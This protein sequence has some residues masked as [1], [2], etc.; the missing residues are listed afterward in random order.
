[1]LISKL[2]SVGRDNA[3]FVPIERES[4]AIVGFSFEFPQEASSSDQFW[5]MICEGRSAST[6][7]PGDRLNIQTFY[8]PDESR[9]ST[10]PVLGGNFVR[11][12]LGKFDAPFFSISPG[13]A[14]FMDPQHRRML[15]TAYRALEDAGIPMEKCAGSDTSVYTGCFTNDYL[16]ILQQDYEAEQTH[17]AVGIAPSMLANRV[18]WF[19][20]FK[21]TSMNIDSACSSSL[22]ALHLACQELLSGS[23][24][25]VNLSS[26]VKWALNQS[27]KR[28]ALVGGANLIFHPNFMKMMSSF[29][30]LSPD[31][32]CWSFDER[33]NGYA[34]GEGCAMLVV[35]RLGD[36]LRDG[37]TIRAVI[38]NTGTNQDGRTPGITQPNPD[39]QVDLIERTYREANIDMDP[40]RFF[41]AHGTGTPVGDPIEANAIGQAFKHCRSTA[42]P[43]YIGTVKANIGHLEGASGLA[44]II[45][46][47]LVLEHGL[48]P[49]IAGLNTLNGRIDADKLFLKFP[50]EMIPWPTS[51][52][53]RACVNSFG[54]GGTNAIVILDDA[55]H[56]LSSR[57]LRGYSRTRPAPHSLHSTFSNADNP[58]R[59]L[60]ESENS[61]NRGDQ[62]LDFEKYSCDYK[63]P[64]LLVLSASDKV[65]CQTMALQFCG[66]IKQY[67]DELANLAYSLAV[68]RSLLTW[69][70]YIVTDV[71]NM[72]IIDELTLP[73]PVR[74]RE[75]VRLAFIFTGQG[76]QY[77]GMGRELLCFPVFQN[78]L[79]LLQ[80]CLERLGASWSLHEF[81]NNEQIDASIDEPRYS[82]PLTTCLQIALVD[83]I[84]SFGILP[85]IVLG[86]SS[87]EIAA[88]YATGGLS[89]FS[90]VKI[91]YYRGLLSSRLAARELGTSMMAVG[92]SRE[93]IVPYFSR[94]KQHAGD[95]EVSIGCVNSPRD[96]TLTGKTQQMEILRQWLEKDLIFARRI[97]VP[98][99]YH[100]VLMNE[101]SDE[102]RYAMQ[103]LKA[104]D[105]R[106][107]TL[108]M[109]S[110]TCGIVALQTLCTVEYWIQN[111]TSTV[112]FEGA[113]NKLLAQTDKK[114]SSQFGQSQTLDRHISHILEI[115]P[116]NAL[117]RPI[118]EILKASP[119]KE[120]PSYIPSLRRRFNAAQ[121]LALAM[122]E[123]HCAGY[124]VNLHAVNSIGEMPHPLP[125]NMPPY[126]FNHSKSYWK[127]GRLSKNFRFQDKARH[128]LLGMRHLDWNPQVAQWRNVVR[129]S[130]LPW[131]RDH[132]IDGQIVL[133]AACMAV[134]ALE[135]FRQLNHARA[136]LNAI[137]IKDV[138]FFHPLRF[139]NSTEEVETQLTLSSANH[140]S[141]DWSWSH[142]RLFV[143]ENETYVECSAGFI[144]GDFSEET[145][146]PHVSFLSGLTVQNWIAEISSAC[147]HTHDPYN[148]R[149]RSTVLYGPSFQMLENM[150]VGPNG[151]ATAT[152]NTESRRLT[153]TRKQQVQQYAIHPCTLDGLA[154]LMV[155]ALSHVREDLP[156]M[157]PLYA[158]NIWIDCRGNP[159]SRDGKL[160]GAARCTL[161]GRRGA[162]AN[163]I[164]TLPGSAEPVIYFENLE[165]AYIE[166]SSDLEPV[167]EIKRNLCTRMSWK[168]DIDMLDCDQLM[169]EIGRNRPKET[170]NAV[171]KNEDLTL[172]IL[173]FIE[174]AA[175]YLEEHS[176]AS[177]PEY[178]FHYTSWITY[179][180]N[181]L[182]N[183]KLRTEIRHLLSR[184]EER[185]MLVTQVEEAGVDGQFFM[186]VGR[187]LI[188]VLSG[189]TD[190]LDLMFQHGLADHYYENVLANPYHA[191]PTSVIVNQLCFKNPLM[192]VLEIGAGTGG[193]TLQVL[194]ALCSNGVSKC[195]RYDY[196]D[197]SPKFFSRAKEKFRNYTDILRFRVGDISKDPVSQGFEPA[198]YDLVIAS[199]VLHAT[200][201]L[202]E[203][204]ENIRKL[205][206]PGGRLLL[207]ETTRPEALHIGFAFGL[208]KGWWSPLAHEPRSAHS[209]CITS[210]QWNERL[211]SAGFSGVD[212]DISGQENER[213]RYSSIMITTANASDSGM[214]DPK[215]DVILIRD[216]HEPY[217][218]LVAESVAAGLTSKTLT[219]EEM[220]KIRVLPSTIVIFLLEMQQ[221]ILDGISATNFDHLRN[222][223]FQAQN[224]I[225]ITESSEQKQMPQH[226]MIEGVCR[227]LCSEDSSRKFVTLALDGSETMEQLL[228]FL[229]QIVRNV[230]SI[231]VDALETHYSSRNAILQI[232]R[233]IENWTMNDQVSRKIRLRERTEQELSR[234]VQA[235]IR[236]TTPGL[237]QT[238]EFVEDEP[239]LSALQDDELLVAVKAI[240]LTF[241]DYLVAAGEV[242]QAN[243]GTECAGVIQKAGASTGFRPGDRVFLIGTALARTLVRVKAS[244]AAAIPLGM[245]FAESASLPTSLWLAYYALHKLSMLH[246]GE[247]VLIHQA[248]SSVGQLLVQL[249][250]K[251]GA[252]ILATVGSDSKKRFLL[253]RFEVPA[254]NIF[255]SN[256]PSICRMI[257]LIT[258]GRGVDVVVGS[259]A[260]W[261]GQDLS[262]CLAAY[263]RV[264]DIG[265]NNSIAHNMA[266]PKTRVMNICRSTVSFVDLVREKP[267]L[268]YDTFQQAIKIWSEHKISAPQPLNSFPAGNISNA[269]RQFQ[270][271]R[272][273]GKPVLEMND[274]MS[275][276]VNSATKPKYQFSESASYVIAGGLGGLGRSFARWMVRRGARY[277]ILLSRSGPKSSVA[278]ELISELEAQHVIVATPQIDI[279]NLSG[280]KQVLS[281]LSLT[282]PPIRGCIQASSAIRDNL[283]QNMTHDDWEISTSSKVAGS[284]NLHQL[285]PEDL[286][287][288]ILISSINGIF[289]NRGQANYAAG[290]AFKD[291]LAHYRL[292]HGLKA[293]SI[294][295]GLMVDEGVVAESELLLRLMR[296]NG[297]LME[298]KQE[299]LIALLDY[300]CD[301]QLPLLTDEEA[302]I[303]VGIEMPSAIIAKGI[304]LHHSIR[305]PIF[306]H[307]FCM[308]LDVVPTAPESGTSGVIDHPAALKS[309]TSLEEA[310]SLVTEWI[311][312]KLG[313]LL[314]QPASDIVAEKPIHAY[315]MDSLIAVDFKN[316]FH[317]SIG[318][319]ITVF[320]LM[321][322]ASLRQLSAV[323]AERSRYR[324]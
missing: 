122:G 289:G 115:G 71:H 102:Y 280:L 67:P 117:Q 173:C 171:V 316:W 21:G 56:Y 283:F 211:Q 169:S 149:S 255:I 61:T 144:R 231:H 145:R 202:D 286:D 241:R 270:D 219:L 295:L 154:Q 85:A 224:T 105:G 197:I 77:M 26:T 309:A 237:L 232:P 284:W 107:H 304:D 298:V 282:M 220:S 210:A 74:S 44:G 138:A 60:I 193:Q 94:L 140:S 86:H 188:S 103:G 157:V 136:D 50:K 275:V 318:A 274:S 194:E 179:Q 133:P 131:L 89:R 106:S 259:L 294:D 143:M 159:L 192:N 51:G 66:Y 5:Q 7:F 200:N 261:K 315:G 265:V 134:M 278:R 181:R 235:S 13:E 221:F 57:G 226:G 312:I 165:T 40:T 213:Y 137:H 49:P 28:Q 64:K 252:N 257:H 195:A 319:N 124:P 147:E 167:E 114:P 20:N 204:L 22:V 196:T 301:P 10:I 198:S 83:L 36:A 109:S 118:G 142:F 73:I 14:S 113:L 101:M 152:I 55:Y 84:R 240:G 243:L 104:G 39:S 121:A 3:E 132:K 112:E 249:A 59:V 163:I 99:A 139:T 58:L 125:P 263:A 172:A 201:D 176:I 75:G 126:P 11:E 236:I 258:A 233:V 256:D 290:N 303:V 229:T 177:I 9:H 120:S 212:L 273:M 18:S 271:E 31:S 19:F 160:F 300:Y 79:T 268:V 292:A 15:E 158:S 205:M 46:A 186:H 68:R 307:L 293:V 247:Y 87:G 288:F 92:I 27:N 314:S 207:L 215:T 29:N 230:Q 111:L 166:G 91:A 38:R 234:G 135:A 313:H 190:P 183:E 88:A 65:G 54:F 150:H 199:H 260:H 8:H 184:P 116:N 90:A 254:E 34:R 25:M 162:T 253:R 209:P 321:G 98:I 81:L 264:V 170:A 308:G 239:D 151:E 223:L 276:K 156:T 12:D 227:A 287:F 296:R 178:L 70:S 222:V 208:L 63:S 225:W 16:N 33:G 311:S 80:G 161:R 108:M 206:K 42:D 2:G 96:V 267:S 72:T 148:K 187:K 277:L 317:H 297:H 6:E 62:S 217:Q 17:A 299:E 246:E 95:L 47:L 53:R 244:A 78:T 82:Q 100:S 216:L 269:F 251:L 52:L 168:P 310:T 320:D 262:G 174:E 291:A 76:A 324:Q 45:K 228:S 203:S 180:Q 238:L 24:S 248:S 32:R 48:I 141:D 281:C 93:D 182:C 285:M 175:Q 279:G 185:Q 191:H 306:S 323:A 69:R 97:R 129:L 322:N 128:D 155:P 41:E 245:N 35:K 43:L 130:E 250:I 30:F 123:L 110:V 164:G 119:V 272:T 242:D 214:T 37:D 4:L 23:T 127:E 153:Q 218:C 305:R 302:Q 146:A 266:M 189:F 1:M